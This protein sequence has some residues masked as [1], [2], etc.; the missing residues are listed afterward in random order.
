M[1]RVLTMVVA[2]PIWLTATTIAK[3][4]TATLAMLAST[5]GLPRPD[6][7]VAPR[8]RPASAFAASPAITSTTSAT[9]RF[10]NH[11]RICCS[12]CDTDG[13]P[14]ASKAVTR[15]IRRTHH[16]TSVARKPAASVGTPGFRA[17]ALVDVGCGANEARK[18]GGHGCH[19]RL[20]PIGD[21]Y[22]RHTVLPPKTP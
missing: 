21:G 15:T 3:A 17:D 14:S 11:S 1:N 2:T 22:G 10:G 12:T 19:D 18:S 7:A 13:R 6:S 9:T 16:L 8:T 5:S 20:A 4:Q